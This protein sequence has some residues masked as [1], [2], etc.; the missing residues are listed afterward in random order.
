MLS[1]REIERLKRIIKIA[2]K[3]LAEAERARRGRPI[4]SK[5]IRRSGRELEKFRATL[6]KERK[7]GI[8]VAEIARK[9]GVSIAYV[10]N[11]Q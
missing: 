4:I 10:Y 8:P 1:V 7:A 5:R 9:H 11:L 3:L 6:K 2:E